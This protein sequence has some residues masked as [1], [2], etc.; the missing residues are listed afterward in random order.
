MKTLTPRPLADSPFDSPAVR[1]KSPA[2]AKAYDAL[3]KDRVNPAFETYRTFLEH[4]Y[5]PAA[6]DAIAVSAIPN[7]A[8]CYDA[9]IS[10]HSS[11]P[12]SAKE[13]H[14]AGCRQVDAIGAE[15]KAS[16]ERRF[17]TIDVPKILPQVRTD[18]HDK[19][20]NAEPTTA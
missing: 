18:P 14:E 9:S 15:M 11:L 20:E 16:A 12:R 8:E 13:V 4:E 2:F 17:N 7:G 5:L 6:R 19:L 1:D 10:Y 3:V